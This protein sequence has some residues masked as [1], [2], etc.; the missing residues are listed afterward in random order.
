MKTLNFCMQVPVREKADIF[1]AG[2]GPAGF[3]AAVAAARQGKKVFLAEEL[4]AFGGLGTV[5]LVP[6]YMPFGDGKR[7]I[8][9]GIGTEV[10]D[11]VKKGRKDPTADDNANPPELLKRVY[12]EMACEAGFDF[13]FFSK[14]VGV[15]VKDKRVKAAIISGKSGLYAVEADVFIDATGDGI[16][17]VFAGAAYEKGDENGK[18]MPSTLCSFWAGLDWTRI[19]RFSQ[20]AQLEKAIADGVFTVEDRHLTGLSHAGKSYGG[21]NIGHAFDVD[22]TDEVS[23]TRAMVEQRGRLPEFEVFYR[24]YM[25]GCEQAEMIG[26][27]NVLGVRESRR[28]VCDYRLCEQDFID[29]A[30]FADEIGRNAYPV[31]IHPKTADKEAMAQFMAEHYAKY[32]YAPGESYGIPY[33]SLVVKNLDNLLVAGRCIDTDLKMQSS[34]RIMPTCY[35]MGQAAGVAAALAEDGLVREISI[36]ELQKRLLSLGAYLPNANPA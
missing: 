19:D 27:A 23:M 30:V 10:W 31:D 26:T 21:G 35:V 11:R 9:T 16:L 28:I 14:V 6:C 34:V 22:T 7:N 3:A 17:S 8:S 20:A 15:E 2:G 18:L 32:R 33:R 4:G 36:P 5:G 1:I 12:D 13:T 24:T 29:R 25:A